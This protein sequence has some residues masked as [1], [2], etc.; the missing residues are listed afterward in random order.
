MNRVEASLRRALREK[1]STVSIPRSCKEH[2]NANQCVE[3]LT[4]ADFRHL[5][6]R[7][8]LV[9]TT[10]KFEVEAGKSKIAGNGLFVKRHAPKGRIVHSC[11]LPSSEFSESFRKS[12]CS[13]LRHVMQVIRKE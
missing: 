3:E 1:D 12:E 10:R 6:D 4:P 5:Y 11:T 2:T 13:C 7:E 9:V 8:P